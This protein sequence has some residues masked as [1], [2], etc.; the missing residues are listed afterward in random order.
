MVSLEV[1]N[2]IAALACLEDE[3]CG[4]ATMQTSTNNFYY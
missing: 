3:N 4:N 2:T 1:N